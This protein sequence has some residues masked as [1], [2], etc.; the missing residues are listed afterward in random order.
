M[1]K[2]TGL[3]L[4]ENYVTFSLPNTDHL[5]KQYRPK[6]Q[7]KTNPKKIQTFRSFISSGTKSSTR[8]PFSPARPPIQ[9]A[10]QHRPIPTSIPEPNTRPKLAAIHGN[11]RTER[12]RRTCPAIFFDLQSFA[13][14]LAR[15]RAQSA[16][17]TT[18]PRSP[19]HHLVPPFEKSRL[20]ID[21]PAR[22]RLSKTPR[23]APRS[24]ARALRG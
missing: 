24:N 5:I 2:N 9:T 19:R 14:S 20:S 16:A 12:S 23:S 7:L 22:T 11:T 1:K 6:K 17:A 10:R 18:R 3:P 4:N 13:I 8:R 21:I 15:K